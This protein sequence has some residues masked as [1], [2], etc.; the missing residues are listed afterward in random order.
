MTHAENPPASQPTPLAP[1]VRDLDERSRRAWTE[2]MAVRPLPDGRYA[3][4]SGSGATYVVDL[5]RGHC[6]CPDSEIRGELCKHA[7]RV[8]IEINQGRLPAPR[9]TAPCAACGR[10]TAVAP[11]ADPPLLCPDC[12]VEPGD[13][14]Y[15][16]ER[17]TDVPMLVVAVTDRRA[18]EVEIPAA[19]TT[20][21]RYGDN[22]RYPA[23]DPVVEVVFP[24]SVRPERPPRRYAFPISRL[25]RPGE[26]DGQATLSESAA[27]G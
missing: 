21:A 17:G 24:R 2:S 22:R 19:G 16:R 14:V 8:A 23:S 12:R 18:A 7:R 13:L 4:D 11:D 1:D 26:D 5:G 27:G 9:R 10:A 6:T 25:A 15:D 3:V 20:V